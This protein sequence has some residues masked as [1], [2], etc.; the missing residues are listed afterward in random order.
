MANVTDPLIN[1]L[2]GSDPQNLMEYLT[3]QKIY[4]GRFWKE[5]CFGLTVAQ[6]LEKAAEKLYCLGNTPFMALT[7][8]LLQLHPETDLIRETFVQQD[9]FKYVRALGSLYLR[10]TGRPAEIYE[11]LE[12][13]YADHCKL[14]VWNTHTQEWSLQC[15]DEWVHQ[16]LRTTRAVGIA[17]PR[18]PHRA[19]LEEAGYLP[20]GRRP[21]AL[22]DVLKEHGDDPLRYFEYKVKIEQ[23][24]AAIAA[25]NKRLERLGQKPLLETSSSSQKQEEGENETALVEKKKKKKKAKEDGPKKKKQKQYGSLF[26]KAN[27]VDDDKRCSSTITSD[28]PVGE[29]EEYWNAERAKL[30]LKPLKK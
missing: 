20:E 9:D 27:K 12:A 28:K 16:L 22:A 13:L 18:L 26:K 24:P 23:S 8:K 25:W 7:L 19:A 29:S 3:R 11:A 4:D 21:T 17:L 2:S 10:L 30:G 14:R 6:V 15:M 1:S 5:E